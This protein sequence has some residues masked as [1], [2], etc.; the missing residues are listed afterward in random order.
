MRRGGVFVG[1]DRFAE[2]REKEEGSQR[3]RGRRK[4]TEGCFVG[5]DGFLSLLK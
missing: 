1:F 2:M 3:R 4:R 5:F